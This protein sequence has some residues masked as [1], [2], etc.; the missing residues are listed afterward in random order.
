MGKID[1]G[2]HS[3]KN[4]YKKT[5][6]TPKKELSRG[7]RE[8]LIDLSSQAHQLIPADILGFQ[9]ICPSTSR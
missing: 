1:E 4:M 8:F 3:I 9:D 7:L 5:V 2:V 6:G